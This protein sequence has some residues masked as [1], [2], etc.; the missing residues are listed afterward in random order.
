M[1]ESVSNVHRLVDILEPHFT[2]DLL[3]SRTGLLHRGQ[4]LVV[5]V[6]GFDGV[7]L[8]LELHDL[9]RGLLEILLVDLFP[10]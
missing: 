8:L 4:S 9:C 3:H 1:R 10:S 7:Y 6:R 5:N 2:M